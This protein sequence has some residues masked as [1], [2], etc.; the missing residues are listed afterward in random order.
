MIA[1]IA[2][3]PLVDLMTYFDTDGEHYCSELK[4][5]D[6]GGGWRGVIFSKSMMLFLQL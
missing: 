2:A 6:G 1:D 4:M 5:T 3:L